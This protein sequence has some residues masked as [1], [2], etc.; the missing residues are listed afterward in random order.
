[1]LRL[2]VRV[3][4]HIARCYLGKSA[5]V[6]HIQREA[7]EVKES[8]NNTYIVYRWRRAI[9]VT[10]SEVRHGAYPRDTASGLS[11]C[12]QENCDVRLVENHVL[13]A[14]LEFSCEKV[15][16]LTIRKRDCLDC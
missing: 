5:R 6:A 15:D 8:E 9:C 16:R 1:M 10:S 3:L 2:L 7:T 11:P 13:P 14:D 12:G 4:R